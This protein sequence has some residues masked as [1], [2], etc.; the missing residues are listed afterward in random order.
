MKERFE[1]SAGRARLTAALQDQQL[2]KDGSSIIG[3]VAE[4]VELIE[5]ASREKIIVEDASDLDLYFI[6]SGKF[7][8]FVKGNQVAT[9]NVGDSVGEMSAIEHSLPRAADVIAEETSV[10]ARLSSENFHRVLDKCPILWKNLAKV[11]AKRLHQRNGALQKPNPKP[12]VFVI[13]S[14][15]ALT[16]AQEIQSALNHGAVLQVWTDGVFFASNYALD[17]LEAAVDRSDFAIAVVQPDDVEVSRKAENKVARDNVIFELGLFMGRLG[18]KRTILFQPK[19]QELKLP[20]DLLGI[21]T[22][23][24]EVG[25]EEDLTA[26]IAT[27]CNDARKI[28]RELGV[29][30]S[31]YGN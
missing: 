12:H 18:R 14:V 19:G 16:V 7:A 24:Y 2:F 28:I 30:K 31:R 17:S 3:E 5:V 6:L 29:R 23:G 11:L 8:I 15:E 13:S 1:G 4:L 20:S 25:R 22:I 26:Y 9:R 21:T 10:V 27:A